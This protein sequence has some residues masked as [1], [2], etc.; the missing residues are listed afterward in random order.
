MNTTVSPL[1]LANNGTILFFK[2]IDSMIQTTIQILPSSHI[3][4]FL[5]NLGNI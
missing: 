3:I 4:L 5:S 2:F 1:Y